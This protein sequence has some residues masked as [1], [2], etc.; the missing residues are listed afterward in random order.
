V[1][2]VELRYFAGLGVDETAS[3]LDVGRATVVRRWR[4][5]RAWLLAYLSGDYSGER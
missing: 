3:V 5:A 1:R 4:Y 2:V